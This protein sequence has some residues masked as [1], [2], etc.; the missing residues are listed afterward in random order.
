MNAVEKMKLDVLWSNLQNNPPA[1]SVVSPLTLERVNS[2]QI[3]GID[4]TFF[5]FNLLDYKI[6]KLTNTG[7]NPYLGDECERDGTLISGGLTNQELYALGGITT[8][9]I[10][11]VV[12][13]FLNPTDETTWVFIPAGTG[14]ADQCTTALSD[15]CLIYAWIGV[16][17]G[18]LDIVY[19]DP[20]D[21]TYKRV[22]VGMTKQ[23][24]DCS[25]GDVACEVATEAGCCDGATTS[26]DPCGGGCE[27]VHIVPSSLM[28]TMQC[29][30]NC[31]S[32]S[33]QT[34]PIFTTPYTGYDI[35]HEVTFE[36][37]PPPLNI[38][39]VNAVVT[40]ECLNPG[41]SSDWRVKLSFATTNNGM[42][43]NLTLTA[44][45]GWSV[46]GSGTS[47]YLY[48]EFSCGDTWV[49]SGEMVGTWTFEFTDSP[50]PPQSFTIN[51]YL[52]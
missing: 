11:T 38:Y 19:A 46:G 9:P 10:D 47:Q 21:P 50:N 29:V 41:T 42:L 36:T 37:W 15:L 2:N 17:D 22:V 40:V 18:A 3:V 27:S 8:I 43:T 14:G 20:E 44:Y 39:A 1:I 25:T 31:H 34:A 49:P 48:K 4:T 32:D 24:T 26:L 12:L 52:K 35:E 5:D 7:A 45:D 13:G 16:V 23:I 6:F 33:I 28:G 51:Y 30:T